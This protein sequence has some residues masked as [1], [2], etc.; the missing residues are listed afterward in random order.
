MKALLLAVVLLLT[1]AGTVQAGGWVVVVVDGLLD[2]IVIGQEQEVG[3]MLLQH[4]TKPAPG[5]DAD[6]VLT[7]RETGE[8]VTV[9]A[10]EEGASGHYVGRFTLSRAGWWDWKVRTWGRD[11]VMPAVHAGL[12]PQA[13]APAPDA[14]DRVGDLVYYGPAPLSSEPAVPWPAVVIL[15]F[16]AVSLR[17]LRKRDGV[18]RGMLSNS[19]RARRARSLVTT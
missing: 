16:V 17:I 6:V 7:H 5:S 18:T 14:S 19:R 3:F 9:R 10:R 11:H 15:G 4:G 8:Q 2:G 13:R 1:G 12:P